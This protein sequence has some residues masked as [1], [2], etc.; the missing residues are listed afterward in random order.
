MINSQKI[1]QIKVTWFL[2]TKTSVKKSR[3]NKVLSPKKL[4][5]SWEKNLS[6]F[7]AIEKLQCKCLCLGQLS[8]TQRGWYPIQ[9]PRKMVPALD[10]GKVG[11][12]I[13]MLQL[14]LPIQIAWCFTIAKQVRESYK[15][16]CWKEVELRSKYLSQKSNTI[17]WPIKTLPQNF[18]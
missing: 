15:I 2:G 6:K 3:Q 11:P 12:H 17:P 10:Q 4:W 13:T 9:D 7:S 18:S 16:K 8:W 14:S 5:I 1:Y